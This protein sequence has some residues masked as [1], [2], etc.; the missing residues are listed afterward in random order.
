MNYFRGPQQRNSTEYQRLMNWINRTTIRDARYDNWDSI[1]RLRFSP[2]ELESAMDRALQLY[3]RWLADDLR[4]LWSLL[5]GLRDEQALAVLQRASGDLRR[6]VDDSGVARAH[7]LIMIPR[8]CEARWDLRSKT[9]KL[10]REAG[11]R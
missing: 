10:E 3:T 11:R 9:E 1:E 6:Y 5:G 8:F 4:I 7:A 2:D